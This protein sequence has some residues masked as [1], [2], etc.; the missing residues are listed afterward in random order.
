MF[1]GFPESAFDVQVKGGE[2]DGQ[3]G[4]GGHE[5]SRVGSR[6]HQSDAGEVADDSEE[7]ETPGGTVDPISL[8]PAHDW[9]EIMV[10][11]NARL[12][13]GSPVG[14]RLSAVWE[15]RLRDDGFREVRLRGWEGRQIRVRRAVRQTLARQGRRGA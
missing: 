8:V 3:P 7:D 14:I 11:R 2:D 9:N 15:E 13:A 5:E 6:N 4:N 1:R 12:Q 10:C